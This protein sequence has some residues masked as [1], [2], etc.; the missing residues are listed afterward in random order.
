MHTP[1][2]SN[3]YKEGRGDI[4][5]YPDYN[6]TKPTDIVQHA[7]SSFMW[8]ITDELVGSMSLSEDTSKN[9]YL[10]LIDTPI[11]PTAFLET[12]T[13]MPSST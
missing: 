5:P 1:G 4:V 7:Y 13:W 2:D 11:E 12:T 8:A 3:N 9:A 6:L 10:G